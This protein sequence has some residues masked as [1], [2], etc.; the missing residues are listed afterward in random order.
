MTLKENGLEIH[1][2]FD[3]DGF[4]IINIETGGNY[5]NENFRPTIDVVINGVKIHDMFDDN[6]LRWTEEEEEEA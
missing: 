2:D 3:E 5:A 6:D 4:P 1:L